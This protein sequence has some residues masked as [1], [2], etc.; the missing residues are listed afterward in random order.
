MRVLLTGATGFVGSAILRQL[1]RRGDTVRTLV[2]STSDQRNLRDIDC[3][4]Y[5]GDINDLDS[6]KTAISD[7]QVL[8]HVAADYRLWAP[9]PDE[10][11]KTNVLGTQNI[12]NAAR[13]ANIEKIIYTSS[14]A[15]LG[16]N[17]NGMPA[18]ENTPSYLENMIGA[19]K[20]SKF[21]AEQHV[22]RMISEQSLPAIIVNPSAPVGPR[23][24]KPTPTGRLIVKAAKG[25]IPAFINTGLNIVHVDD[26][27]I[28]HLKALDKGKIGERY[29][30]GGEN[31]P[32]ENILR[33]VAEFYGNKAPRIRVPPNI[34]L[35][36]A[37]LIQV[38]AKITKSQEPFITVN[39]VK[40]SRQKM[41]YTSDKAES[42]L[43]YKFRP[44]KEAIKDALEW[45][46][47]QGYV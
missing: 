35:P 2:R 13:T 9:N 21:I 5:F 40:M 44:A 6:I 47:E 15:T 27:A 8:F 20:R 4:V 24:L 26:V 18:N 25:E 45:F 29:I 14:V 42:E 11:T 39:G 17:D 10:I 43:G 23:D 16:K 30:L 31:L 19:Y 36:I 7:C 33:M 22:Q 34:V 38:W 37:Y 1:I 12:V 28:G 3:E 46:G 41:Y 32:L